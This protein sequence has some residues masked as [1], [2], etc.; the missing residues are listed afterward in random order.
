MSAR[1]LVVEI[2]SVLPFKVSLADVMHFSSLAKGDLPAKVDY[3]PSSLGSSRM[4]ILFK[5]HAQAFSSCT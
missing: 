5:T 4:T 3:F 2:W 1:Y